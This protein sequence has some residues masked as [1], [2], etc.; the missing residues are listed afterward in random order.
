MWNVHGNA[1]PCIQL[2]GRPTDWPTDRPT[3]QLTDWLT[4]WLTVQ[5]VIRWKVATQYILFSG[6]L[7]FLSADKCT[8]GCQNCSKYML[9]HYLVSQKNREIIRLIMIDTVD[10][11]MLHNKIAGFDSLNYCKFM[12]INFNLSHACYSYTGV[13]CI[14]IRG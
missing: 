12:T 14:I 5:P 6:L 9:C 11:V 1:R 8:V 7:L 13:T 2:T 3:D 4:D 10:L